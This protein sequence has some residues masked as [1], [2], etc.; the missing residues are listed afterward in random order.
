VLGHFLD[1]FGIPNRSGAPTR[2]NYGNV[3]VAGGLG[4]TAGSRSDAKL[5][6]ET[7]QSIRNRK[8]GSPLPRES[9]GGPEKGI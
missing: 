5:L 3:I 2:W 7:L 4:L 1:T 6:E 9:E 8:A